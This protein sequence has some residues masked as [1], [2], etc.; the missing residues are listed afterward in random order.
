L[1]GECASRQAAPVAVAAPG[2]DRARP[3]TSYKLLLATR[4]RLAAAFP[5]Q[6]SL[7]EEGSDG[8]RAGAK[9]GSQT[10]RKRRLLHTAVVNHWKL[11][12]AVVVGAVVF[13]ALPA[14]WSGMTRT[15]TAWNS[16]VLLLLAVTFVLLPQ[17]SARQL[18]EQYADDDP[19]APVILVVVVLAAIL[20]IVAIVMFLST[21]K[22]VPA[23]QKFAH[24]L[25]ATLT[26]SASWLIVPTFYT[27]HYADLFYSAPPDKRPLLFPGTTQPVF[28]DFAYFSFTIAAACQT[29]DV[30]TCGVRVRKNVIAHS[31]ISVLFN[32]SILG[33]AVNISAGL[34]A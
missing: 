29:A 30:A 8:E 24:V 11:W 10:Q 4:R 34:L 17:L 18:Q 9:V 20:S 5:A 22:Q 15:L 28:W 6:R 21:L 26:I 16:T 23:S 1:W 12:T 33:F 14:S 27:L 2:L 3:S 31:V 25:L 32:V 19:T 7:R 13:V